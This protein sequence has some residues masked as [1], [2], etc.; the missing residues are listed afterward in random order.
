M[1]FPLQNGD[2]TIVSLN[3]HKGGVAMRIGY[4][5]VAALVLA[6]VV[7]PFVATL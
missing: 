4:V 2:I 5:F 1:T 6:L 3:R 7:T